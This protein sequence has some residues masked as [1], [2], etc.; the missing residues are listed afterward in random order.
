MAARADAR[1]LVV[2]LNPEQILNA[3]EFALLWR[4]LPRQTYSQERVPGGAVRKDRITG[5]LTVNATGTFK[6]LMV[7]GKAAVPMAGRSGLG[8]ERW[9]ALCG[10]EGSHM[11]RNN[12]KAWMT[13]AFFEDWLLHLDSRLADP[14]LLLVDN[15]SVHLVAAEF[16]L[17]L[18]KIRLECFHPNVTSWIQP[19]DQGVIRA[20]KAR[21]RRRFLDHALAI[22]S[23]PRR[24]GVTDE[25]YAK[26]VNPYLAANY[27]F[28]DAIEHLS[29]AFDEVIPTTIRNCWIKAGFL[30]ENQV[31]ALRSLNSAIV[32]EA[33]STIAASFS[34][35]AIPA[36][37]N[38]EDQAAPE[39]TALVRALGRFNSR[40]P[41][42]GVPEAELSRLVQDW[43]VR[44]H[45]DADDETPED[46]PEHIFQL[47]TGEEWESFFE[48]AVEQQRRAAIA[49]DGGQFDENRD[50]RAAA[51]VAAEEELQE[52]LQI[53]R[54]AMEREGR[55]TLMRAVEQRMA[56]S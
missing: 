43:M 48:E 49:D 8:R 9:Q 39:V 38:R 32:L 50:P 17:G 27:S 37:D 1:L 36:L 53:V 3:D 40:A 33:D 14:V 55:R 51:P 30:S 18:S 10:T 23:R 35:V 13:R 29:G 19:A 44:G 4:S 22:V 31:T 24:E 7:I 15:A 45:T 41:D 47:S 25:E 5:L 54:R 34:P 2:H 46:A 12:P 52:A 21:Y 16:R 6:D 56:Q 28:V 42:S 11:Y 20:L 26:E